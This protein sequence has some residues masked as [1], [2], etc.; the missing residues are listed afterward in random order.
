MHYEADTGKAFGQPQSPD[1]SLAIMIENKKRLVAR[2]DAVLVIIDMQERLL[3][4]I[5]DRDKILDN[6]VK[7]A[8]FANILHLPVIVTEQEKLGPT[9]PRLRDELAGVKT[10][11]KITFDC[12]GEEAFRASLG[13]LARNTL[14][15]A[16]IEAHICVAQTA[17]A[18]LDRYSVQ[19]VADACGS[20]DPF[21]RDVAL[22]RLRQ[23][24]ATITTTEM[25]VYELLQKAGTPEF[26]AVLPL[27]K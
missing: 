9:V 19:I 22:E 8:Q 17:L 2:D 4:V 10:F 5:H 7:L 1:R 6:T 14:I 15:L 16:G 11:G 24:G 20:R 23:E 26:K 25:A 21:N 13:L 18:A 12:F 3:P 27:V